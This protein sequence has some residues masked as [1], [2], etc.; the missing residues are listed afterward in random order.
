MAITACVEA[1]YG[2]VA[3]RCKPSGDI[4]CPTGYFCCSDDPAALSVKGS[5]VSAM[6]SL[7]GFNGN[8][9]KIS[10]TGVFA[11]PMAAGD[12]N[13]EGSSG[14]CVD[15]AKYSLGPKLE[16]SKAAGCP[17]PCN[18]QWDSGDVKT[19]CG[20]GASC[21]QTVEIVAADC[22]KDKDTGCYH[23]ATGEDARLQQIEW[24]KGEKA[25]FQAN[26]CSG[27]DPKKDKDAYIACVRRL[28]VA[29]QRGFC[30]GGGSEGKKTCPLAA[31][32]YK[33]ACEQLNSSNSNCN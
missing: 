3:F 5:D 28:S 17:I 15:L 23:P 31:S 21:C 18:P 19:V 30:V 6:D 20:E 9:S 16:N 22:A 8:A 27:Y 26:L 10:A 11:K 7:P 32:S 14:M 2:A 4:P 33:D 13:E 1:E 25:T 24:G 29:D 12:Q